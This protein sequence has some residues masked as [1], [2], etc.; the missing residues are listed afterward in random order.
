MNAR[1]HNN[2]E[3]SHLLTRNTS[4]EKVSAHLSARALPPSRSSWCINVEFLKP[5]TFLSGNSR[6]HF[7]RL[8][9]FS[10]HSPRPDKKMNP[11]TIKTGCQL[12]S[13]APPSQAKPSLKW[14]THVSTRMIETRPTATAPLSAARKS[15][16]FSMA[17]LEEARPCSWCRSGSSSS[18]SSYKRRLLNRGPPSCDP[19]LRAPLGGGCFVSCL[20]MVTQESLM[21]VTQN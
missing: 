7:K 19:E 13:A 11:V 15:P 21:T 1:S 9:C 3:F 10:V 5:L 6:S 8:N 2:F 4:R 12:N 17:T 18:G 16:K 14:R 20:V